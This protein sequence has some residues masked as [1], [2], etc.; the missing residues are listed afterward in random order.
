GCLE[1]HRTRFLEVHRFEPVSLALATLAVWHFEL[2][3]FDREVWFVDDRG[4]EE[5]FRVAQPS[6]EGTIHF[7]PSSRVAA[8]SSQIMN[9]PVCNSGRGDSRKRNHVN[10]LP[11]GEQATSLV[12]ISRLVRF[13]S[14]N[15]GRH[16]SQA[17]GVAAKCLRF[18]T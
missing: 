9:F 6:V 14:A 15:V 2:G 11:P 16:S 7:E 17:L 4:T 5:A 1:F 10:L 8:G 3:N 13:D 18:Q 12:V